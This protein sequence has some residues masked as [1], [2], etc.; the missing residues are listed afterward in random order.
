MKYQYRFEKLIKIVIWWTFVWHI[1]FGLFYKSFHH[2][3]LFYIFTLFLSFCGLAHC[4]ILTEWIINI[5]F[6]NLKDSR[7]QADQNQ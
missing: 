6:N 2:P 3:S 4:C 5:K 1:F 7:T